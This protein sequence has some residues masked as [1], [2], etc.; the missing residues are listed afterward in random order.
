M[1]TLTSS[2][3]ALLTAATLSAMLAV[4]L[5]AFGA[6]A[7]RKMVSPDLLTVYHTGVQYHMYHS[8]GAIAVGVLF[9]LFPDRSL[10]LCAGWVMLAGIVVFSGSLYL[11]TLTGIRI[12]G[13]IT[14][15]GGVAF[16]VAWAMVALA[17]FRIR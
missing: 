14:P 9:V 7:L 16:I 1:P 12:L 6:H 13:A 15:F 17:L 5:G 11:M 8:L 10:L 4:I 2:A 3:R